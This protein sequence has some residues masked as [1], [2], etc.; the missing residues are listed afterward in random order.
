MEYGLSITS[1]IETGAQGNQYRS[2]LIPVKAEA[3]L[4]QYSEFGWP[5]S[6]KGKL[7]G[8]TLEQVLQ[9]KFDPGVEVGF[10]GKRYRFA[11]LDKDG[12]FTLVKGW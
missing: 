12:S 6:F 9:F 3:D 1:L 8:V 4:G 5:D 10:R 7:L 2:A 11:E